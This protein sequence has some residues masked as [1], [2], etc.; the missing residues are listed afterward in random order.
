MLTLEGRVLTLK[1]RVLTLEG[2]VAVS[3]TGRHETGTVVYINHKAPVKPTC[4]VAQRGAA[5]YLA[6]ICSVI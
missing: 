6:V 2:R 4:C 1:V 3:N 5:P